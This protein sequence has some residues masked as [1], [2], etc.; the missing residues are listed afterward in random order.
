M[1]TGKKI[2]TSVE[3]VDVPP[4]AYKTETDAP[5]STG[6][7]QLSN[8]DSATWL[9]LFFLQTTVASNEPWKGVRAVL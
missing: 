9:Y 8:F 6:T 1:I 3:I 5:I 2:R 7:T 4:H